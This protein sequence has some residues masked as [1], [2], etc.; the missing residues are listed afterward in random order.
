MAQDGLSRDRFLGGRLEIL[1]PLEG[2]RA[3]V[4]PVLLAASVPAR[5]GQGVLELG[6]GVGVASLCLARRVPG[7]ALTGVERDATYA[8][9]AARNGVGNGV[10]L[11]VI[12][13]DLAALPADLRQ[14]SF[15]HVIF[16]PPYFHR[17]AGTPAPGA[18]REA[19]QGE[20]TPLALWV[21]VAIRRL[22]PKGR[23][24]MIHRA[25]QLP[26]VLA[27]LDGRVGSVAV[28]PLAGRD[29]RQAGRVIVQAQKAARGA[30]V[31]NA[32]IVLHAGGAHL[33][34][35][36][37]YTPLARAVLRDAAALF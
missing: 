3:G 16:N 14:R 32:P 17:D 8:D 26:R 19:A 5:P 4:D 24:S 12:T 28:W 2:Y 10:A 18:L 36:E 27:A 9:L 37:D 30:F 20:Q 33:T 15:D 31:L 6:C 23:L 29:A 13:A 22:A 34:D 25:D 35:G 21:D 7:L 11:E 1:Q